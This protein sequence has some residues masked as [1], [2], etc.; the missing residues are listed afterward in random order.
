MFG[1]ME[2]VYQMDP[3]NVTSDFNV[4]M[5]IQHAAQD[6]DAIRYDV[7][8]IREDIWYNQLFG[9]IGYYGRNMPSAYDSDS[10]QT[11]YVKDYELESR[12]SAIENKKIIETAK[13][14]LAS[15]WE[16]LTILYQN[17]YARSQELNTLLEEFKKY[18]VWFLSDM[19]WGDFISG[20]KSELASV[21][22][23]TKNLAPSLVE[24][25]NSSLD[26]SGQINLVRKSVYPQFEILA[27]Q[28]ADLDFRLEIA[29]NILKACIGIKRIDQHHSDLLDDTQAAR[30]GMADGSLKL[31]FNLESLDKGTTE[32]KSQ[33][34]EMVNL[35]KKC[36]E[37]GILITGEEE[38]MTAWVKKVEYRVEALQG[39]YVRNFERLKDLKRVYELHWFKNN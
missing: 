13:S 21:T 12:V 17:T 5:N 9:D 24:V 18:G 38:E 32:I 4:A 34:D 39:L 29:N 2:S 19:G 23:K 6:L 1:Y 31:P 35:A 3:S 28:L 37:E 11:I 16:K 27:K 8:Q 26:L 10:L 7:H 14:E 20:A 22:L 33:I 30:N 25:I 15:N 36:K